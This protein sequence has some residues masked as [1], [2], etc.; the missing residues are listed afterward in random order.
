[1]YPGDY[2]SITDQSNPSLSGY[3]RYG[4]NNW[5]DSYYR[6]VTPS[7]SSTSYY[8][9]APLSMPSTRGY[10]NASTWALN[11]IA[12][13]PLIVI[14]VLVYL[15]WSEYGS[16][17]CRRQNCNNRARIVYVEDRYDLS[18]VGHRKEMVDSDEEIIDKISD[19][20]MLN[21]TIV[22][23]RRSI[24]VAILAA[25]IILL[26]FCKEFPHGFTVLLTILIIFMAVQI[27]ANW[28][29]AHW[30]LFND[31]RIEESLKM[32]RQKSYNS[33]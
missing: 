17:D 8:V 2:L 13:W 4:C 6:W 15:I 20:L 9:R 7:S 1:M 19:N 26:I 30:W 10:N 5:S 23:W 33:H 31:Y 11:N 28:F 24:I 29:Q 27:S 21:H 12:I 3:T 22:T 18:G 25:I 16:Q 32:L 14:V